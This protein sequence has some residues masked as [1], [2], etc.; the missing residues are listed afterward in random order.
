MVQGAQQ[1]RMHD[2]L[3]VVSESPVLQPE[4]VM[5]MLSPEVKEA[6]RLYSLKQEF[7]FLEIV[8]SVFDCVWLALHKAATLQLAGTRLVLIMQHH[9]MQLHLLLCLFMQSPV[10]QLHQCHSMQHLLHD[11]SKYLRLQCC[12]DPATLS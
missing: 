11:L 4:A 7:G 6:V 3:T 1:R 8:A 5:K 12:C 9:L 2:M 10:M